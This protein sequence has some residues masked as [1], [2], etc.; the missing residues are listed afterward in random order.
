[1]V[2]VPWRDGVA[3]RAELNRRVGLNVELFTE[4]SSQWC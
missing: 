1:M 2:V 3:M 4:L